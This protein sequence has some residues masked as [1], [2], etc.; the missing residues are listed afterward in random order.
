M[1]APVRAWWESDKTLGRPYAI[2]NIAIGVAC[3]ILAALDI[4]L[5]LGTYGRWLLALP[6]GLV[7]LLW[8]VIALRFG[9]DPATARPLRIAGDI[10]LWSLTL[11][12]TILALALD[13]AET[14]PL[15]TLVAIALVTVVGAI[16]NGRR[17]SLGT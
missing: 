11:V 7:P 15:I 5:G 4:R 10:A 9:D 2:A 8:G 14:G 12:F 17:A 3:L 13:P 16:V 6:F 1:P